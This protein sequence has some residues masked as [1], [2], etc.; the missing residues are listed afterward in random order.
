MKFGHVE[1]FVQD[2]LAALQFYREVLGCHVITVQ[3]GQFV[4]LSLGAQEI[5]LRPGTKKSRCDSYHENGLGL[6]LYT[7]NLGRAVA[8]LK[9]NSVELMQQ[10]DGCYT[11]C[12]SDGHWF[13]LVDPTQHETERINEQ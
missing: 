3:A 8:K 6:V 1:L 2:P 5:L 13:Q 12:D 7:H 10:A 11:F 4:W 9:K